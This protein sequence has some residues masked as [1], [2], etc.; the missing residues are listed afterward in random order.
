MHSY[1]FE[2]ITEQT[3]LRVT[4]DTKGSAGPSGMDTKL[5]R[6]ILCSKNFKTVGKILREQIA[7]L[8]KNLATQHY[9][10]SMVA[11]YVNSWLIPL[12]KYQELD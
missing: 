8:A 3:V 12:E 10:P 7:S 2:E 6:G 9:E 4:L 11:E 1:F 5:Y